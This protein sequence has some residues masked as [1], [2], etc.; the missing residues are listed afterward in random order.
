MSSKTSQLPSLSFESTFFESGIRF[1]IGI[2][3]V[4]RGSI[5]G[6]VAV[7]AALLDV[8][9]N[10]SDWP[11]K[12]Q[13]SKLIFEKKREAI[14]ADVSDWVRGW[15]V[16]MASSD[17]IEAHGIITALSLAGARALEELL[18]ESSLREEIASAGIQIILDGSHNWLGPKA[19]GIPVATKTKADRDCVSVAAASVLAKVTRDRLM[20]ELEETYP[21]YG[22]ASN[23]GYASAT[24]IAGLKEKG[25]SPI[26]RTSWLSKII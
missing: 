23:K 2:D 16:G 11:E 7:G 26:H 21:G 15:A 19:M 22:L 4:G 14:F 17:E 9:I 5:A 1:V 12:L 3:E 18:A 25:I 6:P 8:Q 13:D 10:T 24:H 20:I